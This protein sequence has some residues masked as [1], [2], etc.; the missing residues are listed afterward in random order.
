[1][2]AAAPGFEAAV[3]RFLLGL[4]SQTFE[5]APLDLLAE[6]LGCDAAKAAALAKAGV[7][8]LVGLDGTSAV[9]APN[10]QNQKRKE[11][12][13][14]AVPLTSLLGLYGGDPDIFGPAQ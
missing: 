9:F 8:P 13:E 5:R 3:R 11:V 4:L 7:A 12:A 10:E 14:K 2:A 1:M 6:V